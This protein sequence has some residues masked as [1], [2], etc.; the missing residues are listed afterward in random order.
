MTYFNADIG[1]VKKT[2]AKHCKKPD[3]LEKKKK[4]KRQPW[5]KGN[6]EKLVISSKF[7]NIL[8][9]TVDLNVRKLTATNK[10]LNL[11]M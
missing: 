1:E 2:P 4:C 10:F 5:N 3:V 6:G 9:V 11:M 7:P 8:S